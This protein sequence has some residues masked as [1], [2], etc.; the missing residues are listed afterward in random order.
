[1]PFLHRGT[2][3]DD[4]VSMHLEVRV[5]SRCRLSFWW[6]AAGGIRR[7]LIVMKAHFAATRLYQNI[8][9]ASRDQYMLATRAALFLS[10]FCLIQ[11]V[12]SE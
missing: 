11:A 7:V 10:L 1:M 6:S 9:D 3:S 5:V 4:E 2:G 8:E 12:S